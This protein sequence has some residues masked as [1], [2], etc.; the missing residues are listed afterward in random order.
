MDFLQLLLR[1]ISS[2]ILVV[3][4]CCLTTQSPPPPPPPHTHTHNPPPTHPPTQPTEAPAVVPGNRPLPAWPDRGALSVESLVVRYRPDLPPVLRGVTFAAAPAEKVGVAGRTGCGKS[5][6]MAALFRLVE[7]ASGRVVIDGIDVAGI[8]LRDLRSRLALVPQDPVIFSGSVRSNLD[9]F[10]AHA[11][12]GDAPLW[13]GL[14][15]AGL[16]GWARGLDGGLDARVAEGG[17]D[18]SAGQRQLLCLARALLRRARLLVLDEATSSVDPRTDA[19]IQTALATAFADCTVLTIAHRLHTI[20][21]ADRVLVLDAGRV[22]E[23]APPAELLGRPGGAFRAL[24]EESARAGRTGGGKAAR[25]AS[26]AD[27]LAA[28]GGGGG[29]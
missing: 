16:E 2:I 12:A 6:L 24:V 27:L 22:A 15:R 11:A 5:T 3:Y 28:A 25:A 9:P 17:G 18:L 26:A 29:A 21:G 20:M 8:G 19:A 7:P 1:F 10:A 4:Y 13:R 23:H 14:Q